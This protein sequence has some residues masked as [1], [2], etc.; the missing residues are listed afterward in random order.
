MRVPLLLIPVLLMSGAEKPKSDKEKLQGTWTVV[1]AEKAGVKSSPEAVKNMKV[2]IEGDTIE[3]D[4]G[5]KKE[6]VSFVLDP[7]KKLREIDLV[8]GKLPHA[9]GIYELDGDNLKLCWQKGGRT[10]PTEFVSKPNAELVLLVLK[11]MK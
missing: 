5:K 9:L 3:I 6:K 10:R 7:M 8:E 2:I 4:D 11:R 1:A